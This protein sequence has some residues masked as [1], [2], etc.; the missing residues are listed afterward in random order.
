MP[1]GEPPSS[2]PAAS[3]RASLALILPLSALAA[4]LGVQQVTVLGTAASL[5]L[6]A[7]LIALALGAL[8]WAALLPW[9]SL[10]RQNLAQTAAAVA[11]IAA[12]NTLL[13]PIGLPMALGRPDLVLPLFAGVALALLV[14]LLLAWRLFATPAFPAE[15]AWPQG[16]ATAETLLAAREGERR[17]T[18]LVL[19]IAAGAFG[20]MYRVPMLAFGL[21]FL[22]PPWPLLAFAAGLLIRGHAPDLPSGW[23]PDLMRAQIPQGLLLGAALA[24]V[25]QLAVLAA[26][27]RVAPVA[28][29]LAAHLGIAVLLALAGGLA[30][31]LGPVMLVLFVAYAAL[32][33]FVH[34]LACGLAAMHTGW[35]PALALAMIALTLGLVL[36][37]P[38]AALCLVTGFTAATGP[39]FAAFGQALA[40]GQILREAE[41]EAFQREGHRQQLVAALLAAAIALLV[42]AVAHAPLFAAGRLPPMDHVYAIA[43][44]AGAAP[45]VVMR[46]LPWALAGAALQLAGGATRQLGLLFAT[47]LMLLNPAA[48]WALL[49][50]LACREFAR[51]RLPAITAEDQRSF[52]AGTIAGD[53]LYGL[54]D[55]AWRLAAGRR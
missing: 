16:R 13:L 9:R 19:G 10:H 22:A 29:A 43:I 18:A 49:A 35:L 7:A 25:A 17:G 3:S 51:R 15:A 24:A 34:L 8:P 20:A 37:F 27:R 4:W 12:G 44:R 48:G 32:A 21:A 14:D 39:A 46:M 42:V 33:A 2:H 11:A 40:T 26:R 53:A 30:S 36:G 41:A 38:P 6:P 50:G 28:L 31:R 45:D 47:G 23:L 5:A 54:Y 52:A 1:P 55:S